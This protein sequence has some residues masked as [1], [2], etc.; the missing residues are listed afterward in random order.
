MAADI[1]GLKQNFPIVKGTIINVKRNH[2]LLI[3][4]SKIPWEYF[5]ELAIVD[6]YKNKK[7]KKQV[8]EN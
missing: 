3:L 6:L 1:S 7:T 5:G 4:A 8:A 2:Q